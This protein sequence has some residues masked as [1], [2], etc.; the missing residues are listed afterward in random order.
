MTFIFA[1]WCFDNDE[2]SGTLRNGGNCCLTH[3]SGANNVGTVETKLC[4]DLRSNVVIFCKNE[5]ELFPTTKHVSHEI[6]KQYTIYAIGH[7][8]EYVLIVINLTRPTTDALIQIKLIF[9]KYRNKLSWLSQICRYLFAVPM[10][11][12]FCA[13]ALSRCD[14]A[15]ALI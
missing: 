8:H 1:E 14:Y 12:I 11:C 7:M 9:W 6:L 13:S 15:T 3:T 4:Q 10:Q 2:K 5:N